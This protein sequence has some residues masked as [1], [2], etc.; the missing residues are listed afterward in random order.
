MFKYFKSLIVSNFVNPL[1]K[2]Y[3]DVGAYVLKLLSKTT[4]LIAVEFIPKRRHISPTVG[5]FTITAW[6]KSGLSILFEV[7]FLKVNVLLDDS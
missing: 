5:L 6:F 7:T 1:K 2:P 4:L 3:N